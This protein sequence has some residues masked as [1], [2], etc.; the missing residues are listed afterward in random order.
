VRV[1]LLVESGLLDQ[2]NASRVMKKVYP[3]GLHVPIV[4]RGNPGIQS[5]L[6]AH[7]HTLGHPEGEL[8]LAAIACR[9]V[10]SALF[11]WNRFNSFLVQGGWPWLRQ[12]SRA[13]AMIYTVMV[14][15]FAAIENYN[16]NNMVVT[17]TRILALAGK[18]VGSQSG[19]RSQWTV[20]KSVYLRGP[21]VTIPAGPE[22]K[23]I[24]SVSRAIT[25]TDTDRLNAEWLGNARRS[26]GAIPPLSTLPASDI[27]LSGEKSSV[28]QPGH[29]VDT[30]PWKHLP[31]PPPRP[32]TTSQ[33]YREGG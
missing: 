15:M 16:M 31:T 12:Y 20:R 14:L 24:V 9:G 21:K 2:E 23:A 17:R 10:F 28:K 1:A 4:Q 8:H 5:D 11:T 33:P 18:L 22:A 6:G 26:R 13:Y 19:D 30:I 3:H 32:A 27:H 29:A 7:V 25:G